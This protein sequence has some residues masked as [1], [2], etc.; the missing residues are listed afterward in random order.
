MAGSPNDALVAK[1]ITAPTQSE[2]VADLADNQFVFN[3]L[4][5]THSAQGDDGFIIVINP[6]TFP[7]LM[8]GGGALG[9]GLIGPCGLNL[10]HVHPRA[11]EIQLNIGGGD[12]K[13]QFIQENGGRVV[14]NTLSPGMAT[15]F[16]KGSLHFQQN[17]GCDP[18]TFIASFDFVDAGVSQITKNLVMLDQEVVSASLGNLGMQVLSNI[19]IPE[20]IALGAQSCLDKCGIDR[21]KFHFNGTFANFVASSGSSSAVPKPSASSTA[22]PSI[23]SMVSRSYKSENIYASEPD[24]S[25]QNNPLKSTVIGLSAALLAMMVWTIYSTIIGRR[26][27]RSKNIAGNFK[28]AVSDMDIVSY[29]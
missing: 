14:T 3:F 8:T 18:V 10:P 12:L 7:A 13:A 4:N 21:S 29:N 28:D 24:M 1:L 25:F 26:R 22:V 23:S 27:S 11:N 17:L 19:M 5:A 2:R 16:P 9:L 20:N 15:V 6:A